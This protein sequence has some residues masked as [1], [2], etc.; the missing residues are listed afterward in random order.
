MPLTSTVDN[1][2]TPTSSD[3]TIDQNSAPVLT[4]TITDTDGNPVV[5]TDKSITLIVYKDTLPTITTIFSLDTG[6]GGLHISSN[7]VSATL[8]TADTANAGLFRYELK[9]TTDHIPLAEGSFTIQT[10]P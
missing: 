5:L 4:W 9:N 1:D 7:A 8:T 6:S 10:A 3:V 2:S